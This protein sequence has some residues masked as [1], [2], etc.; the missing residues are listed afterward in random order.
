MTIVWTLIGF[1][2]GSLMFSYWI[3]CLLKMNIRETGDGNPGAANLWKE[4]GFP[5]GLLGI[6]LDFLK[7]Y[8]PIYFILQTVN[9]TGFELI[10]IALA[11]ILGHAFS[12]F[13]K[14]SGGKSLAVTFGVWS[15]LTQFR[16]SFIYALILAIFFILTKIIKKGG[17]TSSNE[18]GIQTTV[19]FFILSF[20]LFYK[21]YPKFMLWIW[22][23]NFS[24]LLWKN[25][26]AFI[27]PIKNRRAKSLI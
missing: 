21:H 8:V 15:A 13:L 17:K 27:Q 25:R 7:G 10:P 1:F 5:F 20:Y 12:P 26:N 23:G 16:V 14:F 6:A 24:I 2:S 4:A 18:D 9:E 11:P 22:L 19:G 3:G